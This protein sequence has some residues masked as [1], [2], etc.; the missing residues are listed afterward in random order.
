MSCLSILYAFPNKFCAPY[1][2]AFHKISPPRTLLNRKLKSHMP[3]PHVGI[4]CIES[5]ETVIGNKQ[6]VWF[7]T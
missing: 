2:D 7:D 1:L 5:S 6:K 3:G 4:N